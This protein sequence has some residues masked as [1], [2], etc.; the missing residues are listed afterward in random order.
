[1]F[2]LLPAHPDNLGQRAIKRLLLLLLLLEHKLLDNAD[3]EAHTA[4]L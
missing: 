3:F 1:V 2:L 4:N